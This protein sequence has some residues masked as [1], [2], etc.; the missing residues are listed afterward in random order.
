MKIDTYSSFVEVWSV[1]GATITAWLLL[2]SK[3]KRF[4]TRLTRLGVITMVFL[5]GPGYWAAVLIF[6]T[7]KGFKKIS[8]LFLKQEEGK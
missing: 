7:W 3:G 6:L 2:T 5:L 4:S 1:L 8:H